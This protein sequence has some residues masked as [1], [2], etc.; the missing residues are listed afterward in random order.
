MVAQDEPTAEE[1]EYR[2]YPRT[3]GGM[4]YLLILALATSA[5]VVAALADWRVGVRLFAAILAGAALLRLLLPEGDAGMLA[6]RH[7]L[8]DVALLAGVAVALWFL[9][10]SIPDQP[11]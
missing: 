9:A 2:R 3:L 10:G 5:V 1:P 6:V 7:R 11:V 4:L 8:V